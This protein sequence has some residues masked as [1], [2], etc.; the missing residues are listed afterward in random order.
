MSETIHIKRLK[1]VKFEQKHFYACA[2]TVTEF[3]DIVLKHNT[4]ITTNFFRK[5]KR[6]WLSFSECGVTAVASSLKGNM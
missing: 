4:L 1:V 3:I 2:L 5:R 6:L